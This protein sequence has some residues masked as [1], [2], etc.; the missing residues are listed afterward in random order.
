M[1]GSEGWNTIRA[2]DA[3]QKRD[4]PESN[5][6]LGDAV[7]RHCRYALRRNT[8]AAVSSRWKKS[9]TIIRRIV[10]DQC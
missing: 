8:C 6:H 3:S 7:H 5:A 1:T 9:E 2:L 10:L 4:Q